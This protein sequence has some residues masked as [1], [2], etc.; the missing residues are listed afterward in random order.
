MGQVFANRSTNEWKEARVGCKMGHHRD[1]I[2]V[3]AKN[4]GVVQST[5]TQVALSYSTRYHAEILGN[6]GQC[7]WS[8]WIPI[9]LQEKTAMGC[10]LYILLLSFGTVPNE[11][12]IHMQIYSSVIY[13]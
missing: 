6:R 7:S 12:L 5:H 3:F 4:K 8:T 10:P 13:S 2:G 11:K 9:S 1:A